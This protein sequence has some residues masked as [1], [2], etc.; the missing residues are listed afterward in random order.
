MFY[1]LSSAKIIAIDIE[2]CDPSISRG[3]GAGELR[4][5][6]IVG[7]SLATDDGFS[8]YYPI[9]HESGENLDKN[10][11]FNYL[12]EQ[13]NRNQI[14]LG[15]NIKYDLGYL[16][17][18]GV[19]VCGK[20]YDTQIA[21]GLID[22]NRGKN[23][24]SLDSIAQ[25]YLN[26]GKDSEFLYDYLAAK[27]GG[28]PTREA[29]AKNIWRAPGH[30]VRNYAI[31]DVVLP[32]EIYKKQRQI[33]QD[34]K[35]TDLFDIECGLIP[36][37]LAM[38]K[39]GIRVNTNRI[40]QLKSEFD[41]K[42]KALTA[43]IYAIFGRE[44]NLM[45][46]KQLAE[47]LESLGV[48]GAKTATGRL[49][50]DKKMLAAIQ[51]PV[52]GK[53]LE[54]RASNTLLNTFLEGYCTKHLI[55]GRLHCEL[56]SLKSDAGGTVT[57][58]F[59]CSNPNLQNIPK[60]ASSIIRTLFLPEPEELWYS[61]DYSQIEYRLLV[62]YA[63]GASAKTARQAYIEDPKT[64][65]H[66]FVKSMIMQ[67]TNRDIPRSHVKNINFGLAYTMGKKALAADLKLP[68]AEA[69]A[70]FE[71]YHSAVPFVQETQKKAAAKANQRGYVH[72]ILGR[73]RR[74]N[75]WEPGD[76]N[77]KRKPRLHAE[78]LAEYGWVKRAKTKDALN[79][80]LQGSCADLMKLS[81]LKIWDAGVCD[82]LGAP[83]ITVH[84]ELNWSV[85]QSPIG[86]EAHAEALEIMRTCIPL[87][88]PL[89]VSSKFGVNW[90][91]LKE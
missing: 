29:Q 38:R 91:E 7:V 76:F 82:V 55:S 83:L 68:Q 69:D 12:N 31:S 25:K 22:E 80:I 53:L 41:A 39:R 26:V 50:T 67:R 5:G 42:I 66:A 46:S 14:K 60:T 37:L 4:D 88:V 8:E 47:M 19:T 30:I 9:A 35:L 74:F 1:D 85:P 24:Y 87:R 90:G 59:S 57:G 48:D 65:Y 75:L 72:T 44:F 6:F 49:S 52:A 36:M 11:V 81:M 54:L 33:L 2:T 16:N 3:M 77:D 21:E 62:H 78:A 32:I 27:F 34:E 63:T 15:H 13:L 28:K 17:K 73:R 61:D 43:E 71:A 45:S 56:H 79:A 40:E 10:T 51:H 20:I 18:S 86:A 84:D 70:L 23:G 58:R 64:D 89:L